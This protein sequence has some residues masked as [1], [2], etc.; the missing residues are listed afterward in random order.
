VDKEYC[1][2]DVVVTAGGVEITGFASC[3]S[4]SFTGSGTPQ[5]VVLKGRVKTCVKQVHYCV[6]GAGPVGH[7][8]EVFKKISQQQRWDVIQATPHT[9]GDC[10]IFDCQFYEDTSTG[11]VPSYIGII[12]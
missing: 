7:P 1:V 8:Q 2:E 9:I 12:E 10:W 5:E 11:Y 4:I 3:D 6:I